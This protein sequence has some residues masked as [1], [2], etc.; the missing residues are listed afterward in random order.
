MSF[1]LVHNTSLFDSSLYL[2]ASHSKVIRLRSLINLDLAQAFVILAGSSRIGCQSSPLAWWLSLRFKSMSLEHVLRYSAILVVFNFIWRVLSSEQSV[3]VRESA[4]DCQDLSECLSC[5]Q[6]A[7]HCIHAIFVISFLGICNKLGDLVNKELWVSL[8]LAM[9]QW[10]HQ[11]KLFN[12]SVFIELFWLF[13]DLLANSKGHLVK[14]ELFLL[15]SVEHA[16]ELVAQD[17]DRKSP[18]FVCLPLG[19]FVLLKIDEILREHL[20]YVQIQPLWIRF[21]PFFLQSLWEASFSVISEHRRVAPWVIHREPK[22]DYFLHV[23]MIVNNLLFSS[24]FHLTSILELCLVL[25]ATTAH[26]HLQLCF[27]LNKIW[28]P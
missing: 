4:V 19:I 6:E 15:V 5:F 27:S 10:E 7:C 21:E 12:E 8:V 17:D 9:H 16:G 28:L 2:F 20:L 23:L 22:I 14:F 26:T 11:E 3:S 24:D 1:L 13:E 18:I 25:G